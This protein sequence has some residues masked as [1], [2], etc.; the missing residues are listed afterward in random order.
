[1]AVGRFGRSDGYRHRVSP[2]PSRPGEGLPALG[3]VLLLGCAVYIGA[4]VDVTLTGSLGW[5]LGIVL[6]AGSLAAAARVARRD[7]VFAVVAPPLAFAAGTAAVVPYTAAAREEGFPLGSVLAFA[8]ALGGGAPLLATAV[9]LAA[10]IAAVRWK[11]E[12]RAVGRVAPVPGTS[13]EVDTTV[14]TAKDGERQT[15]AERDEAA[16]Q[17]RDVDLRAHDQQGAAQTA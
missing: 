6:V 4:L 10:G 7:L 3:V 5:V 2:F 14:F 17:P 13:D 15:L 1:M 16:P 11:L 9:L 8:G 12:R